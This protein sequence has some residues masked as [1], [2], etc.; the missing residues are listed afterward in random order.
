MPNRLIIACRRLREASPPSS[1]PTR[2][3][4]VPLRYEGVPPAPR[5]GRARTPCRFRLPLPTP[6]SGKDGGAGF[7]L[8]P[9]VPLASP[10]NQWL[11]GL[12][13]LGDPGAITEHGAD[14]SG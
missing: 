14:G 2:F 5:L 8:A 12:D 13:M 3:V 4:S 7:D 1:L 9:R 11:S 10:S 6:C